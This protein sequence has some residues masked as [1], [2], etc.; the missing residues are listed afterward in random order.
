MEYKQVLSFWFEELAPQDRFKKDPNL[1]QLIKERFLHYHSAATRNELYMWRN[2]PDSSLAEIIILDQFSRN[3]FRDTP[4][5][6][7]SDAQALTLA[8]T[9]IEKGFDKQMRNNHKAF[10]YM[11]FMHS[12]SQAIHEIALELYSQ[13]GL[14]EN[15]KFEVAH[16]NII[17]RFGRYPH[18]NAILKR[19][20]TKE[21]VT[22]LREPDSSF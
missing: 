9:A 6:F 12:E 16:K 4:A 7:A 3:I 5:S 11:P 14:E 20:S 15:L 21:E 2:E 10:L 19:E 13:K 22:F 17:E 18:R 1:D 8:Q